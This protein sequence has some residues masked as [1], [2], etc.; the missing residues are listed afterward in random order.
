[1]NNFIRIIG[2]CLVFT[3]VSFGQELT[4]DECNAFALKYNKTLKE[5]KWKVKMATLKKEEAYTH[6]FPKVDAGASAFKATENFLKLETPAMNLPI[7]DGNMANLA[8]ATQFAFIPSMKIGMLDYG[9][10]AH[11]TAVQPI[12]AGGQLKNA[13]KLATVGIEIA[14]N[15]LVLS[16]HA[17]LLKTASFYWSIVDL[18]EKMKTLL[19]YELMVDT[20]LKDVTVS[21]DAGLILRSDVLKVRLKKNEIANQKLQLSNGTQMLTRGLCQHIGKP[22]SKNIRLISLKEPL[23]NPTYFYKNADER[24]YKRN[25]YQ[26][27]GAVTKAAELQ[28]SLT[29]GKL[30]PQ[31]AVGVSALYLD[32]L[33]QKNGNFMAFASVNIPISDWWAGNKKIK[34]HTF[35]IAIAANKQSETSEL[36]HLEMI[37]KYN[38]LDETYQQ[39]AIANIGV[40]QATAHYKVI[41]DNYK[42]GLINTTDLLEAQAILQETNNVK[43]TRLCNYNISLLEYQI[44]I[45]NY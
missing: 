29:K 39:I 40:E 3:N 24:I 2:I 18:K 11:I 17:V 35:N 37:Q 43:T 12:Y 44:A 41:S 36:L 16:E 23:Q 10:M 19:Q 5:G 27:L 33:D 32:V 21:F 30:M 20:L 7:Y 15:Q 1:M 14:Q 45:N 31:L 13:N 4:L 42:A 6:Y 28:L 22:F 34:Q 8:N 9:N 26:L 38:K 25:E